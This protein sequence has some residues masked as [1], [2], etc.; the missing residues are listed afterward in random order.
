MSERGLT[1]TKATLERERDLERPEGSLERSAPVVERRYDHRDPL[2]LRSAAQEL[3]NFVGDELERPACSRALEEAKGALQGRWL[4]SRPRSEELALQMLE[5]RVARA[6]RGR[7]L[8]DRPTGQ[9]GQ[10]FHRA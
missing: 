2:R 9:A 1:E 7:Q 10:V 3:E 6:G 5:G 8:L 4:G